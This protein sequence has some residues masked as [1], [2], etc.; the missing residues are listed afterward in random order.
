MKIVG[1]MF[2]RWRRP[3]LVRVAAYAVVF[4][5]ALWFDVSWLRD[6]GM[7]KEPWKLA[8][9]MDLL[10]IIVAPSLSERFEWLKIRLAREHP[11]IGGMVFVV[12]LLLLSW[13]MN[14][15]DLKPVDP[16]TAQITFAGFWLG[17]GM[18]GVAQYEDMPF[19]LAPAV[20]AL[21]GTTAALALASFGDV[22]AG[23]WTALATVLV[24]VFCAVVP[25]WRR[26]GVAVTV[27]RAGGERFSPRPKPENE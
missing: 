4:G 9:A 7:P 23:W 12:G 1:A 2:Q 6:A 13:L 19:W 8:E 3:P 17:L 24:T 21:Q 25:L 11:L 15:L 5:A 18:L 27:P 20:T 22:R 26:R 16:Q 10:L 14:V